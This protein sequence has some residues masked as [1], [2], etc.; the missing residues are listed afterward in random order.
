MIQRQ[1]TLWLLVSTTA[2]ILSFLFP[3]VSGKEV[4]KTNLLADKVVDAG[5]NFFLLI[6]T[7]ASLILSTVIIFLFKNRKQQ[8][9]L[10]LLGILLTLLIIFLYILQM[11]KLVKPILALSCIL[12]VI[13]LI[14]YFMAFRNI[15]KDEKLVK[16]LDKLR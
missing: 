8:M 14:G 11:N 16:S 12:P 3:F 7:G 13:I 6:L 2:G 15:R 5:S 10:C 9:Q 1:Q 4:V